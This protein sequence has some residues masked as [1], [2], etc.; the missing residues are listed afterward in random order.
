M[1]GHSKKKLQASQSSTRNRHSQVT[2]GSRVQ[3]YLAHHKK[4]LLDSLRQLIKTPIASFITLVVIGI[5]LALPF[6][7]YTVLTKLNTLAQ[8]WDNTAQIS[9]FLNPHTPAVQVQALTDKL[10]KDNRVQ[11]VKVISSEQAWQ[12]LQASM[13]LT[14]DEHILSNNPLPTT[15]IITTNA[16]AASSIEGLINE[17]K[18]ID[19]VE[20]A[21]QDITWLQRLEAI[22]ELARRAS[23]LLAALLGGAVLFIIGNTI[24]M[25]ISQHRHEMEVV[26][27][28]G[29]TDSYVRRPFL[30][31]GLWL[32]GGGS[33]I[34]CFIILLGS[35]WLTPAL[36]NLLTSYE[37]M[38]FPSSGALFFDLILLLAFGMLLGLVG[39]WFAATKQLRELRP[40]A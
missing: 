22:I 4:S 32:G 15:L 29:A 11:S 6:G 12:E 23:F 36:F 7:F 18:K 39:A 25:A 35:Y 21:Q 28:M 30:Y 16:V 26:K 17:L 9:V 14:T 31:T 24:R 37:A 27:L 38:T 40:D 5:A 2:V 3:T 19:G 1:I 13:G 8:G 20:I 10:T 34:A 33:L